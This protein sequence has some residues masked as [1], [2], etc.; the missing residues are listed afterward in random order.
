MTNT[1]F[2]KLKFAVRRGYY[3][4]LTGSVDTLRAF[5]TG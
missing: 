2:M 4:H 1:V 3:A 5:G